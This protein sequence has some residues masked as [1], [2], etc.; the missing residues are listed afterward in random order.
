MSNKWHSNTKPCMSQ[1][2]QKAKADAHLPHLK[3]ALVV[4]SLDPHRG[5]H[6]NYINRLI[7]GLLK[8]GYLIWCF[9][10]S[11][12]TQSVEHENLEKIKVTPCKIIPS[13]RLLWFNFHAQRLVRRHPV[14]FDWVFTT[15]NVTFGNVYRAGGGVHATYM[16]NCLSRLARLKPNHAIARHFQKILFKKNTPRLLITNSV[17]VKEDIRR[18]YAVPEDRLRVIRNGIDLTRFNPE[19]AR[20][21][22]TV[23]RQR[24]GFTDRDFVCL[25]TAGGRGRKGLREL[26]DSFSGLQT[27]AIKLL[28]VGRTDE[29]ELQRTLREMDLLERVAY[30]GFQTKIEQFYGAAD[31]FVFPSKYDAAANVVCE[32]LASGVPV[33]TTKTNGS[34]ELIE[35][36]KNGYVVDFAWDTTALRRR[37]DDLYQAENK[38]EMR[39]YSIHTGQAFSMERHIAEI[40]AALTGIK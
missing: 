32:A 7:T 6:E 16:D 20:M 11:F 13:L 10:E 22:R 1:S 25:F 40:D 29:N 8:R 27:K 37:I 17:M 2:S 4:K 30:A 23:I 39:A 31:C 18:R 35:L 9:A 36:A 12:G 15:G 26:L 14:D 24:F 3:L 21:K 19:N 28:I 34:H 5:G 33:I 38:S